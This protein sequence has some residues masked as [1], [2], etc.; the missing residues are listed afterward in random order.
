MRA[1]GLIVVA[2]AAG[3]ATH[4][5]QSVGR[6]YGQGG[7][8][9]P[10]TREEIE[11]GRV[12]GPIADESGPSER[13]MGG[14][15]APGAG[16]G[17][18]RTG[19]DGVGSNGQPEWTMHRRFA[20]TPAYVLAP[21][22]IQVHEMTES[23][24]PKRDGPS[25][26]FVTHVAVGLEGG[27]EAHVGEVAGRPSG[28]PTKHRG[29]EGKVGYAFGKWGEV[30]FNPAVYGG[31]QVNHRAPDEFDVGM[32]VSDEVCAGEWIWAAGVSWNQEMGDGRHRDLG[33]AFGIAKPLA[34]NALS[35]GAEARFDNR[36]V[37]GGGSDNELLIGPSVQ[38]RP[39]DNTH[40]GVVPLFGVTR[41]DRRDPRMDLMLVLGIDFGPTSAHS[42]TTK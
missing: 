29:F 35:V 38:W 23:R 10:P 8:V 16:Y 26:K 27:L 7:D 22:Q 36:A 2:L 37:R 14:D 3:C 17:E 18:S 25:H 24:F 40:I 28:G 5:E 30:A 39:T 9:E 12:D 42:S 4:R 20:T 6:T 34:D 33:A 13:S 15:D 31:V 1:A 32:S 21:G 41:T 11:A 19:G